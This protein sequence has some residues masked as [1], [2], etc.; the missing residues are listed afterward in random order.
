MAK[1]RTKARIYEA[2]IFKDGIAENISVDLTSLPYDKFDSEHPLFIQSDVDMGSRNGRPALPVFSNVIIQGAFDCSSYII[3]KGSILPVGITEL[4][5]LYSI[6]SLADLKDVLPYSVRKLIVRNTILKAIKENKNGELIVA[7]RFVKEFPNVEVVSDKKL[8]LSDILK[9]ATVEKAPMPVKVA[10]VV[11]KKKEYEPKTAEWLSTDELINM[12]RTE[13]PSVNITDK[14]IERFIR[15][16]RNAKSGLNLNK[17]ERIYEGKAFTCIHVDDASQAMDFVLQ[18][19]NRD[20]KANKQTAV[21]KSEPKTESVTETVAPAKTFVGSKEV[22]EIVIKKYIKNSVWKEVQK[23]C[24]NDLN[25]QLDFL[26]AIEIINIRPVMTAG[27]GVY[28]IQDGTVQKSP[29]IAFKNVQWLAQGFGTLDDRA[30]IIWCMNEH[31]FIATEYFEEHEKKQSVDYKKAIR[32]K[33][34]NKFTLND[35]VSVSDLIKELTAERDAKQ[36]VTEVEKTAAPVAEPVKPV[37][38]E[39]VTEKEVAPVTEQT[40]AK[41]RVR[42]RIRKETVPAQVT[43]ANPHT[44]KIKK[45]VQVLECSEPKKETKPENVAATADLDITDVS[46]DIVWD[47]FD[48]MHASFVVKIQEY[49]TMQSDLMA[50]LNAETNTDVALEYVQ[51][52]HGILFN[53]KRHEIVLDRLN[54]MK[55]ELQKIK[56]EFSKQM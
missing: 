34:V 28:Y 18:Q 47:D 44:D 9:A 1:A 35:T 20:T 5:C 6:S 26:H 27:N 52:L 30:R 45:Q 15:M 56:Q 16:A 19:L 49:N 53:K 37:V 33:E 55:Q 8:S 43:T 48:S 54:A 11:S 32:D 40:S 39:P 17:S 14:E 29:T 24:K 41:G 13:Y 46:K 42:Q 10:P 7:Q 12:F 23:H 22:Q 4:T 3:S 2:R 31:G 51:R 25:K 21:K 36:D 50:K 38:S